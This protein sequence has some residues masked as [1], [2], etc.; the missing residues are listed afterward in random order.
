VTTI[1]DTWVHGGAPKS[2][3]LAALGRDREV[4]G[5]EVAAPVEQRRD[6]LVGRTGT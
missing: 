1:S 3:P 4:R 5:G 6:Q 2:T